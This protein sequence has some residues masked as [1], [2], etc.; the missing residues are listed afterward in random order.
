MQ[1]TVWT[2]LAL[3]AV[4]GDKSRFRSKLLS[5]GAP[6]LAGSFAGLAFMAVSPANAARLGAG[7]HPGPL[8]V[9]AIAARSTL[10][11]LEWVVFSWQRGLTLLALMLLFALVTGGFFFRDKSP[12]VRT[13]PTKRAVVLLPVVTLVAL[14]SSFT[15]A[16]YALGGP[17]PGR[18]QIIPGFVLVCA[19]ASWGAIVG[20]LARGPNRRSEVGAR[21]PLRQVALLVLV[22]FILT[23]GEAAWARSRQL[24]AFAQYTSLWDANE[25]RIRSAV[26]Q[27]SDHVVVTRI[28]SNW[29]DMPDRELGGDAT[30][31]INACASRYYGIEVTAE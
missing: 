24:P 1:V 18:A 16:A 12:E 2:M 25:A 6:F 3:A 22:L 14:L 5:Q 30:A 20:Q 29:A 13:P 7:P 15:P 19:V 26:A 9:V 8:T 31:W 28:I 27:G 4:V 21:P 11:F 10:D 23:T 17:P